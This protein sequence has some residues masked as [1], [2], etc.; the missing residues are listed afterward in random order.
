MNGR[1]DL[2]FRELKAN[3]LILH[4]E[5][6]FDFLP[7]DRYRVNIIFNEYLSGKDIELDF[8]LTKEQKDI[9]RAAKEFAEKEFVERAEEFDREES[10][11]EAI[12]KKAA[13]LGFLGIF[14]DEKYGGAGLGTL[15]Q[16]LLQEEFAAIDL[17]TAVAVLTPCFGSEIIQAFGTEEQKER[18]LPPLTRGEAIMGSAFTEP[19]AGSDMAAEEQRP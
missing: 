6:L 1:L 8:E 9:A 5:R 4:V 7:R 14:I 15:E 12:C 11:D 19:D 2:T 10:F 13:E 17:G 16:C 3:K 18:Y